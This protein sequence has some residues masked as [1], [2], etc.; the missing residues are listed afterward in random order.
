MIVR[1]GRILCLAWRGR[2]YQLRRGGDCA[3]FVLGACSPS[4]GGDVS[5]IQYEM[6]KITI[7][8]KRVRVSAASAAPLPSSQE[9]GTCMS[10]TYALALYCFHPLVPSCGKTVTS[11]S[12]S[13]VETKLLAETG[14]SIT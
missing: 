10:G 5:N 3:P 4:G 8:G 11:P 14:V 13:A 6:C 12:A 1:E 7:P 9:K 2:V